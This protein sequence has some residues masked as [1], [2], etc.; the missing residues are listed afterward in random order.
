MKRE[1][2]FI[3]KAEKMLKWCEQSRQE[4]Y[5]YGTNGDMENF[6]RIFSILL[7]H[8]NSIFDSLLS[9]TKKLNNNLYIEMKNKREEDEVLHYMWQ[10]RN[11]ETHDALTK[12][13]GGIKET[14]IQIKDANRA[15]DITRGARTELDANMMMYCYIFQ[16]SNINNLC[17]AFATGKKSSEE[18]MQK[19]GVQLLYSID[20]LVLQ[21][22]TVGRNHDVVKPPSIPANKAVEYC[23]KFLK[24]NL[25]NIQKEL[26]L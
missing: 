3:E 18:R 21:S 9:A 2:D 20:S 23:L 26:L 15:N 5:Q 8:I 22:F 14:E 12:W 10:A 11:S 6:E 24:L 17:K 1:F 13:R 16:V 19:A 4:M 25:E 7:T